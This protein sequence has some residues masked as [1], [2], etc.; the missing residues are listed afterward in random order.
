MSKL[1]TS[2]SHW[3]HCQCTC[4]TCAIIIIVI[5]N[6]IIWIFFNTQVSSNIFQVFLSLSKSNSFNFRLGCFSK[7]KHIDWV[8]R[9]CLLVSNTSLINIT[10][11]SVSIH[12]RN[13]H[14][15]VSFL[16]S[17]LADLSKNSSVTQMDPYNIA[18]C[19]APNLCPIP[20]GY[21]QMQFTNQV[22]SVFL[23]FFKCLSRQ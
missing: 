5:V 11:V 20:E 3:R 7:I 23:I 9:W 10:F 21:D 17:L 8:S 15:V 12:Y 13:S 18:I 1:I 22:K 4:S 2:S 16:F 19:F 14:Q 6:N